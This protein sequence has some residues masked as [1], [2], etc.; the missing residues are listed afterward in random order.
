MHH[1]PPVS[2]PVDRSRGVGLATAGFG[3]A[4]LAVVTWWSLQGGMGPQ[5]FVIVPVATLAALALRQWVKTRA[6]ELSWDG[7]EWH[8]SGR[9]GVPGLV[10]VG[11]D[12]QRLLLLRWQPMGAPAEWFWL[13][14]GARPSSWA[15]LRRAVYS[16]AN[17]DAL[18][19][20]DSP[21]ANP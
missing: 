18:P 16:R 4:G 6:G 9:E 5:S 20:A 17:P 8:W 1:A 15:D 2:Y 12:F 21:A 7:R 14:R 13:R 10:A 11:L 19:E 3:A